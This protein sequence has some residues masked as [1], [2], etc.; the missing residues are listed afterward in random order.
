MSTMSWATPGGRV[1]TT[2]RQAMV[3]ANAGS[4]GLTAS[5]RTVEAIPSA[6]TTRSTLAEVP[7]LKPTRTR[8]EK[9]GK[10]S[11]GRNAG[12]VPNAGRDPSLGSWTRSM[13]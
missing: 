3:P 13:A 12:P 2:L 9:A 5:R 8:S 6:P 1:G 4:T 11:G 10:S 7:S